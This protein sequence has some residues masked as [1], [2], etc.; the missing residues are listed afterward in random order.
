[1]NGDTD[2][3]ELIGI[4]WLIKMYIM[5]RKRK[6]MREKIE[7]NEKKIKIGKAARQTDKQTYVH[8]VNNIYTPLTLT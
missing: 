6:N 5:K 3:N 1:M 4:K 7:K 2:D 8:T